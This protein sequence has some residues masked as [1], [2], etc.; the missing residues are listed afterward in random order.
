MKKLLFLYFLGLT[1]LL[2][3]QNTEKAWLSFGT[4]Y[5]NKQMSEVSPYFTNDSYDLLNYVHAKGEFCT[6]DSWNAFDLSG[7]F[8]WALALQK[9]NTSEYGDNIQTYT[10]QT[11]SLIQDRVGFEWLSTKLKSSS[12]SRSY[13]FGKQFGIRRFGLTDF[14]IMNQKVTVHPGKPNPGPYSYQ[15]MLT[16]GFNFQRFSTIKN[17]IQLRYGLFV[18]GAA[19]FQRFGGIAYP[20][21]SVILHKGRI[22]V[23]TTAAYEAYYFYSPTHKSYKIEPVTNSA[24]VHGL[25]LDFGLAIDVHSNK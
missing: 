7:I 2:F 9:S 13:G 5:M 3:A 21:V 24:I 16:A 15:G 22:G 23:I 6:A 1:P 20:E 19:G 18:N 10:D 14:G 8:Y 12:A 17:F 4:T 25:R 11:G